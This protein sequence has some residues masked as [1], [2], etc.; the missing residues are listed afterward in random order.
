MD[1]GLLLNNLILFLLRYGLGYL[2][3]TL[4]CSRLLGNSRQICNDSNK[5]FIATYI[6]LYN[7][8]IFIKSLSNL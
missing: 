5:V 7:F 2:L 1:S 6:H 4:E 8:N 3:C